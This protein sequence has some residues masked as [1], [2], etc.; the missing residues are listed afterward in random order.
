KINLNNN[1]F[2]LFFNADAMGKSIQ[3]AGGIIVLGVVFEGILKQ[4]E[5]NLNL[6]PNEW[7]I[8]AFFELQKSF[9][10]FKGSMLVSGI[11][12]LLDH[13]GK[14][15]YINSEHPFPILY[16]N[17]KASLIKSDI[18]NYKFG[19]EINFDDKSKIITFEFQLL[20]GDSFFIGSDGKDDLEIYDYSKKESIISSNENRILSLI[21]KSEGDLTKLIK[22]INNS[23]SII[24]D[25]SIIKIGPF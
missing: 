17:S 3:G 6:T 9:E 20:K 13:S 16:R 24:D 1:N 18:F 12:G 25:L 11:L 19:T 8:E 2:S 22:Y 15:Y 23:G 5:K 10:K 14:I 7:L 4:S 21:E